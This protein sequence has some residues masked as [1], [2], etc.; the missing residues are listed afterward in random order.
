[1]KV[2]NHSERS[3]EIGGWEVNLR[4]YQIGETFYCKAENISPGA[5]IARSTGANRD[6]AEKRAIAKA[7][8]RL[9]ATRR[10]PI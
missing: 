3:L 8:E 10:L 7:T 1:M 5:T 6:E 9:A 4:T 2:E